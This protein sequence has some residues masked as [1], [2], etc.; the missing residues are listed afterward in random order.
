MSEF[1]PEQPKEQP[2]SAL[3]QETVKMEKPQPE[4]GWELPP[5]EE[6]QK[7]AWQADLQLADF[8]Q[9][10]FKR[11]LNPAETEKAQT[12]A[13]EILAPTAMRGLIIRRGEDNKNLHVL[14]DA[15]DLLA[16]VKFS[17]DNFLRLEE[18]EVLR[19]L[20]ELKIPPVGLNELF[21]TFFYFGDERNAQKVLRVIEKIGRETGNAEVFL[22]GL[23]DN[24]ALL[25]KGGR[26]PETED[27]DNL[28]QKAQAAGLPVLAAKIGYGKILAAGLPPKKAE[29]LFAGLAGRFLALDNMVEFLRTKAEQGMAL[30]SL[31]QQQSEQPQSQ[32]QTIKQAKEIAATLIKQGRKVDYPVVFIYAHL[33]RAL[34]NQE[35]VMALKK[36][37]G[38]LDISKYTK[39][40]QQK[41]ETA[42]A[43][44]AG[45]EETAQRLIKT[46]QYKMPNLPGIYREVNKSKE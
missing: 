18:N 25:I 41:L 35:A 44:A 14:K 42:Q 29:T 23:E 3:G 38:K 2:P 6:T 31:A 12:L 20:H 9:I 26:Q 27:L 16:K 28:E 10:L 30:L 7:L 40:D 43:L 39:T 34:A 36:K 21:T 8:D 37:Y 5:A 46:Y 4:L 11:R 45:E 13:R 33:I 24:N 32:Q 17:K 19:A 22:R 1:N 15:F